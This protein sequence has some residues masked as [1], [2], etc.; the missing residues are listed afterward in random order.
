MT[1]DTFCEE[2]FLTNEQ[3]KRKVEEMYSDGRLKHK[4]EYEIM[5]VR[6]LSRTHIFKH[7]K[8]CKGEGTKSPWNIFEKEISKILQYG[9]YLE[10]GDLS[11]ELN[12]SI[13]S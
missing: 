5:K 3:K 10:K 7:V 2:S 12:M 11:N 6:K 4:D 1:N 8:V 13:I 9:K